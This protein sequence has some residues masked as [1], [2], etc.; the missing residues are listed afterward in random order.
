MSRN[1]DIAR[2]KY[3]WTPLQIQF[4]TVFKKKRPSSIAISHLYIGTLIKQEKL[5]SK[6]MLLLMVQIF[7][8]NSSKCLLTK[9]R[10]PHGPVNT[11]YYEI[12]PTSK[13]MM[14]AK[15]KL[16]QC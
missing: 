4:K 7:Q 11:S 8:L 10:S 16:L 13:Q 14:G 15:T 12:F 2:V 1:N 3:V 6:K 5:A 9:R